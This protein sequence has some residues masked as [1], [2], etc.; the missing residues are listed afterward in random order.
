MVTKKVGTTNGTVRKAVCAAAAGLTLVGATMEGWQKGWQ[1]GRKQ[2][3]EETLK[4][5]AEYGKSY[6]ARS[7]V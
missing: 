4:T 3:E 6:D 7:I 1:E 5:G 2:E